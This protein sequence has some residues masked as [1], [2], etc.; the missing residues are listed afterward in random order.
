MLMKQDFSPKWKSSKQP[1]KQRKYRYNAP[2]HKRQKFLAATLSKELRKKYGTRAVPLR[3]GDEV[4]V[5]RGQFKGKKVK[6]ERV[7]MKRLKVYLTK[8]ESTKKDGTKTSY[9]VD[10]SNLM[11]TNLD[12]DDKK[13]LKQIKH[14]PLQTVAKQ[15]S[16]Q[17]EKT[18]VVTSAPAA[19]PKQALSSPSPSQS[20]ST[21]EVT[22]TKTLVA[23]TAESPA[24]KNKGVE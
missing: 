8:I 18:A 23:K 9:P 2:L 24:K 15:S 7:D 21:K 4:T 17:T 1:R 20:Q 19:T 12:T 14:V 11:I 13:R 5:M 10:P 16:V 3:I 6:V 22:T